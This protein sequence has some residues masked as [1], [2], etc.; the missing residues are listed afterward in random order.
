M[1]L[2]VV[3]QC[4]QKFKFDV[5]PVNGRMPFT[6]NCPLC[7][8]DGTATANAMLAEFLASQPPPLAMPP[9]APPASGG[10]RINR[11]VNPE[12]A[13]VTTSAPPPL[14]ASRLIRPTQQTAA[15]KQKLE[16]YEHIWCA[17]PLGLV[18]IGGAIGG[19]CGGAAWAINR[20]VF[21]KIN[22]PVL[23]YVVTGL[24]SSAALGA[25]LAVAILIFATLH[26]N[27]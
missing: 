16:W 27:N 22:H 24:I 5:E 11:P 4:G 13:P 26:K 6:V 9:P 17:L 14:P 7:N 8:A 18:A 1:E 25:Y 20:Q 10:L 21:K 2:K 3:C 19:A 12:P 23:R 15:S